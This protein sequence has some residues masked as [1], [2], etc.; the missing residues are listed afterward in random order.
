MITID[1]ITTPGC[2]ILES[3]AGSLPYSGGLVKLRG[4]IPEW[5]TIGHTG[6]GVVLYSQIPTL[7]ELT[8]LPEQV[9]LNGTSYTE[10]EADILFSDIW[11]ILTA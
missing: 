2:F 1:T 6:R 8:L 3:D 10:S 5:K 7:S 9:I 4:L 11:A